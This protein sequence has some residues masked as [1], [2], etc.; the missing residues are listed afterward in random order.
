MLTVAMNNAKPPG[1][2]EATVFGP[3]HVESAPHVAQGADISAGAPGAPLFVA[4]QVR[5]PDGTPIADAKVDVWQADTEG[6]YDVQRPDLG[7]HQARAVLRTDAKGRLAFRTVLPGSYAIP[8]DGPV[9]KMLLATGRHPWRPAHVHFMIEAPGYER[10]V[11]HVF[12]DS[13]PYLDSDVVFGVRHSLVASFVQHPA[14]AL[15]DG[16]RS[17]APFYTLHYDFVLQPSAA[18][19]ER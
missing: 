8:A 13:D 9:G 10:L 12:R 15:P 1:V 5:A 17:S 3:Y 7:H 14:G 6:L 19:S 11:T 16:T 18:A 2:T 4:A